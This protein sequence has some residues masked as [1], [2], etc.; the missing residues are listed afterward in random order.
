VIL[1]QWNGYMDF[2]IIITSSLI[3]FLLRMLKSRFW[4]EE[5]KIYKNLL[6]IKNHTWT[7]DAFAMIQQWWALNLYYL[8]FC[9]SQIGCTKKCP[10]LGVPKEAK[11]S[12]IERI[13]KC[14]FF[15]HNI[16]RNIIDCDLDPVHNNDILKRLESPRVFP[17][18]VHDWRY[19]N[20]IL[21]QC[22]STHDP[23]NAI[24]ESCV[25]EQQLS[26]RS[27]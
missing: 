24:R 1:A 25:I 12:F 15:W 14:F 9:N 4:K 10:C 17:N 27:P 13:Q 23:L 7:T 8:Y 26:Q 2:T 5:K 22:R 3:S 11:L 21:V 19:G 20:K 18:F 16:K 6:S